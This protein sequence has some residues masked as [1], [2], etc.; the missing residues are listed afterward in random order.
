MSDLAWTLLSVGE[1]V[2]KHFCGPSPDCE[3][4][5]I[6]G[7]H[8]WG[9]LK[10]TAIT[11][12][13]WDQRAHKL[14]PRTFWGKKDLEVRAGDVLVTKAGPRHRVGVVCHIPATRTQL[15]VS[16]KMIGL[17]PNTKLVEPRVL[18]G[19][20]SLAS[21][22][23]YIHDRTTG[24]AES[25]V[26][27]AN[28]VLLQTQ[29]HVPPLFEQRKISKILDTLDTAIHETEAIITKLKAVKQGLLHNLLTRG[30]DA[31][32]KLRPSYEEAP[33]L[34][35][36]SSLGW[37]P[38][39]WSCKRL[40][41][42]LEVKL[43]FAFSSH[44]YVEDGILSFRVTNI[45]QPSNDLGGIVKLPRDFLEKFPK[46]RLDGGEIMIVMVGASTGK[47]GRVPHAICPALQNQNMW[48]LVPKDNLDREFAWIA[49]P[50]LVERHMKQAQGSARDFLTQSAFLVECLGVPSLEEQLQISNGLGVMDKRIETEKDLLNKLLIQ[51]NGLL[52]DLLTGR[53][54]VTSLVVAAELRG[55]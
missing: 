12:S 50:S 16:G 42:L 25:Q 45:G 19:L 2:E 30:I 49:L 48:N 41:D 37:I 22:Q 24:M 33:H 23:K 7:E 14:L 52:D 32:G 13:G 39:D 15:V 53:V 46:Q 29:L 26:N 55:S 1:L 34:Y 18:A 10:T 21:P 44:D 17:R 9:V 8:E 35:K 38:R 54:R 27:F 28:E 31:N 40:S 20:I 43:G 5:Q 36:D 11:W 6:F 3:E 47:M 51:K 4:R